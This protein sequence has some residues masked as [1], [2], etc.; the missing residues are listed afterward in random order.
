[1]FFSC[2]VVFYLLVSHIIPSSR[3]DVH[4]ALSYF[5]H[6]GSSPLEI[7]LSLFTSPQKWIQLVFAPERLSYLLSVFAPVAFLPV[8]SLPTLLF[9]APDFAINLLSNNGQLHEIYYQYTASVTP[10]IFIATIY[11]V[12]FLKKRF[13]YVTRTRVGLVLITSSLISARILGPRVS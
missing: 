6:L 1:M 10:F 5:S 11:A 12:R 4:F 3:G 9:A 7:V 8:F 2:F 13:S